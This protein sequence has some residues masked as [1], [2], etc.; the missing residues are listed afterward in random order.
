MIPI[1]ECVN[2][3]RLHID[4]DGSNV[5]YSSKFNSYF[6]SKL[7]LTHKAYK[8]KSRVAYKV[9]LQNYKTILAAIGTIIG[10]Y[11]NRFWNYTQL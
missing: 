9:E 2:L 8:H 6:L 4:H 11:A 10:D 1:L 5:W 3:V 7:I